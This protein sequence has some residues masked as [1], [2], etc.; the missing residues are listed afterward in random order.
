MIFMRNL[1]KNY[2]S[3]FKFE[4]SLKARVRVESKQYICPDVRRAHDSI[5]F[6]YTSMYVIYDFNGQLYIKTGFRYS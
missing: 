6:L 3:K 2:F 5:I 1:R 4:Y